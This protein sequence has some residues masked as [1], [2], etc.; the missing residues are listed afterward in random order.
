MKLVSIVILNCNKKDYLLKCLK[1]VMNQAYKNIEII[2]VDNGSSDGSSEIIKKLYPEIK[3]I[4]NKINYFTCKAINQGIKAS[5]GEY[6]LYIHNDVEL[7]NN[8]V[9]EM[10]KVAEKDENIGM[11]SGKILFEDRKTIYSVGIFPA[12]SR[13][14]SE[15]GEKE[16]DL[17]QY[18]KAKYIFG[19]T[20]AAPLYRRKMLEDIKINGEYF[21]EHLILFY[22]DLDICWRANLLGWKGF[23]TPLAVAYHSVGLTTKT[24]IPRLKFFRKFYILHLSRWAKVNLISNRYLTMIKNDLLSDFL[25][26]LPYIIFYEFKLWCYILIFEPGLIF[27]L[28][29]NL[30]SLKIA[31]KK[32][33]II[34]KKKLKTELISV[35]S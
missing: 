17:G 35:N 27:D 5:C 10:V 7:K 11:V 19:P 6:I 26:N 28:I 30:S 29:K 13:R 16:R 23:Y 25:I 12:K 9:E 15:M 18:D 1:S 21:D 33:K 3:L 24:E 32:R 14:A 2:I 4:E 22:D 31:L 8:F 34:K 20:G